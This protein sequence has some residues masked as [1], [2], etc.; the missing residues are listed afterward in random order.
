MLAQQLRKE[1]PTELAKAAHKQG[2]ASR[3]AVLVFQPFLRCVRGHDAEVGTR[4]GPDI[5]R[6][7]KEATTGY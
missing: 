2:D 6:A 1:S 7:G 4:L 3:G 5:A